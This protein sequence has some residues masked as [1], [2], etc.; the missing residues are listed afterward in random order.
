MTNDIKL[1]FYPGASPNSEPTAWLP[2]E[3]DISQYLRRPGQDGGAPVSYS[4][5]K[6]DESTTTNPGQMTLTL[7][8]RDGRFSSD[9]ID[10]PYYGLL[11]TNTPIRLG[12]GAGSDDFN[13]TVT[14]AL[15]ATAGWAGNWTGTSATTTYAVNGAQGTIGTTAIN[16]PLLALLTGASARDVDITSEI[17][18]LQTATGASYGNGHIVRYTDNNNF[19]W[20]TLEFN[21]AGNATIK[22]R[23]NLAGV[24]TEL[25]SVNP[26]PSS[27]YTAGTAWKLRTQVEGDIVR[28]NAWPLAGT[29]PTAWQLSVTE[30]DNTGTTV[31]TVSIRFTS[32]TNT[33]NILAI[34]NWITTAIEWTG[35]V[36][37]WPLEWDMS[38]N[39]S[40]APITAGGILR[41]LK[42]GT[43]PV[44]SPLRHQLENLADITGYWPMEDG[45]DAQYL[46]GTVFGTQPGT[47]N[48]AL[49]GQDDT[50]QGGGTAPE[51][52]VAGGQIKVQVVQPNGGTG[53][54]AMVMMRFA[55][56]PAA[57]TRIVR[58]RTSRGPAV[59][60]DWSIDNA[61][62][63]YVDAWDNTFTSIGSSVNAPGINFTSGWVALGLITD[64]SGASTAWDWVYHLVGS[65]AYFDQNGTVAGT[66]VSNVLSMELTGDVG[67]AFGHAWMG[68]NT[69]PFVTDTFSLVS[70]G[71]AGET[72]IARFRRLCAEAGIAFSVAG[73][74]SLEAFAEKMGPQSEGT[75]MAALQACA[76]ADFAVIAE[77]GAGLEFIGRFSRWNLAQ[78]TALS[79]AS[80]HIGAIPK[81]TRDDQNLR[82]KWTVSRNDGSSGSFQNDASVARNGT[83]EDSVSLN[84][85]D[86]S[87]LVNHAAWRV[88]YGTN[89]R[90][91]WPSFVMNFGRAPSLI[92]YWRQRFYGWRFGVTTGLTQVKGNEPD[93]VMEG[94]QATLTPELWIVEM[95]CTN[96]AAWQAAVTD[97]TGILGRADQEYCTTTALISSTTLSIPVTTGSVSGVAMPKWDN[98]AGLWSGGV[99]FNVGGERVTVTS[100]TNGAGQAQTLNATVRGVGGYSASHPSGTA[101][102]LWYP[103]IVAL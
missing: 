13:R 56:L 38:S 41:R 23:R 29:Q 8:D 51:I 49:A 99:D 58:V 93:L 43:N 18:P 73:A 72:A 37:S 84:V 42:Q 100:I 26:I 85:F 92:Q 62:N 24:V 69:M 102:S 22:I 81:P 77:R 50:L 35:F 101:V 87:V 52:T 1:W 40:W 76:D 20:S 95:N 57:K 9:K 39:N 53:F 86:D 3:T 21:T 4:W 7:D 47:M 14:A 32:N 46:A 60:W 31:G 11:D 65:T 103:P 89:Q 94:Y 71:Y 70:N 16:T 67:T 6:Q 98:T 36:V 83:W 61:G 64:N 90:L 91:R 80:G 27:T 78:I 48:G 17:T 79:L 59:I 15:G 34:N 63:T 12:V 19:I 28:V 45:T 82:N 30:G 97:D 5:G 25:G 75:T 74:T 66:T 88:A 96:A 10:G 2:Y 33:G 55:S 68:K 54:T 44:K